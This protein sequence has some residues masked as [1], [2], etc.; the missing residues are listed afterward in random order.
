M[1]ST[2]TSVTSGAAFSTAP[3][4]ASWTVTVDDGQPSQLPSAAAWP[5]RRVTP[6]YSHAA[7]VRAEVRPD[8]VEGTLDPGVDI[9][10]MQVVQQQQALDER[11]LG[12]RAS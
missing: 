7:G 1:P 10:R 11:V 5:R 3:S 2:T 9:E 8:L 6:R 4:I 12:Q